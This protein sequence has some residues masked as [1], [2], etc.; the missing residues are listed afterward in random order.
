[1]YWFLV[2]VN[3]LVIAIVFIL[4]MKVS[5]LEKRAVELDNLRDR[6]VE[7]GEQIEWLGEQIDQAKPTDAG[8][9]S[10][11]IMEAPQPHI[12]ES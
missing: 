3:V 10:P 1:L 6:I 9:G 8:A 4:A 2:G 7:I 12:K 11:H 5:S